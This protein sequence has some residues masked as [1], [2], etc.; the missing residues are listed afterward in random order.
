MSALT[1]LWLPILVSAVAIFIASSIIHMVIG[2][3]K[4]DYR[5]L[6]NEDAVRDAIRGANVSL[7]QYALPAC[8]NFK[9]MGN[10]A[11]QQK[12]REGPVGF[13]IIM[14]NGVMNMGKTLGL[15]FFY[16]LV[17]IALIAAIAN[18]AVGVQKPNE[19]AHLIG[20][21]TLLAFFAGSPINAIWMGKRWQA[22]GID[23]LDCLIYATLTALCFWWLLPS[24]AV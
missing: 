10:E 1:M 20:L 21:I 15:W 12:Y 4:S 11:M 14:P 18:Q 8:E 9:E 24:A 17:L 6:T 3:H 22:V 19:T 2:W 5:K 7:G 13:L 23:L 16:V